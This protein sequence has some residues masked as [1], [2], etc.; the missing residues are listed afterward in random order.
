MD[1]APLGGGD[2]RASAVSSSPIIEPRG[3]HGTGPHTQTV[4]GWSE[5]ERSDET[6]LQEIASRRGG[7][8]GTRPGKR[9]TDPWRQRARASPS[10]AAG[11]G[12]H[13]RVDRW[14]PAPTSSLR[15]IVA[16]IAATAPLLA[17]QTAE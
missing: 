17:Q 16:T 1:A 13:Q 7:A 2:P 9:A 5:R 10:S 15:S 4:S 6:D 3:C 14:G 8:P 11:S 12:G